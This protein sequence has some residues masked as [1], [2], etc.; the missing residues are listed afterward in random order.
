MYSISEREELEQVQQDI[1]MD[2]KIISG[3]YNYSKAKNVF[4]NFLCC[5]LPSI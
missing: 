1:S 4:A 3:Y 2:K 5:W